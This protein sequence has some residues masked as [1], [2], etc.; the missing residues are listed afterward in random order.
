V[1]VYDPEGKLVTSFRLARGA[2]DPEVLVYAA[3]SRELLEK[4]LELYPPPPPNA[5]LERPSMEAPRDPA[6]LRLWAQ[7]WARYLAAL[8]DVEQRRQWLLE[9]AASKGRRDLVERILGARTLD[10]L[11][12]VQK[13]LEQA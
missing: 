8:G 6:A 11:Y 3:Y 10:E 5:P 7:L 2:V 9:L 1:K 13:I 12:E 4:L